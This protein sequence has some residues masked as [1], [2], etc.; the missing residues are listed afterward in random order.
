MSG[1]AHDLR[2]LIALSLTASVGSRFTRLLVSHFGSAQAVLAA[3][4]SEL[5]EVEG[6]SEKRVR[7]VLAS[8]F[9]AKADQEI[10]YCQ[11]HDIHVT[12]IYDDDYPYRLKNIPDAPAVLYYRGQNVFNERKMIAIV[13]TRK[14]SDQARIWLNRFVEELREYDPV[15]VSGLAYGIDI[16]AHRS[17]LHAELRTVGVLG[18][19]LS[20]IYP[21]AHRQTARDMLTSGAMISEQF[22]DAQADREHFPMR[23]RILVGMCDMT[24]VV[25]SAIKGGSMI[26]AKLA[27]DYHRDVY[28]RPGRPSDMTSQGCNLLIKSHRAELIESV[29]DLAYIHQWQKTDKSASGTQR[30]LFVELSEDERKLIDIFTREREATIEKLAIDTNLPVSKLSPILLSLEFKG[31]LKSLPGSRYLYIN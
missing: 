4:A 13:G 23:N 2:Y 24:I 8:D 7:A 11:Q 5:L 3:S 14:P 1:A 21:A 16:T 10:T 31:M 12:T 27:A 15:I 19:G 29:K 30:S 26:S 18:S 9:L 20:N 25:E 28:A 17:A 22:H 6:F